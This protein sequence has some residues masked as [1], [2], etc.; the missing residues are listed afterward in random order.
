MAVVI[1]FAIAG[2]AVG[3]LLAELLLPTGGFL[4]FLGAVGLVTSG[5]VAL[6]SSSSAAD[7][8]GAALITGGVLSL[9]SFFF[10]ARKVARAHR[11][12]QV[13]TGWEEMLGR[14]VEV[15][16]PL[17]PVGHVFADGA[18]WKA[19]PATEG[20]KIDVGNRV[21]VESVDGL[22]LVVR[23]AAEPSNQEGG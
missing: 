17:D 20:T 23:P 1:V 11:E 16:A 12:E 3:L 15:R 8:V 18:L 4:A 6:N 21:R 22:T 9:I 5:V 2:I 13:R 7:G 14:V 10:V 19:R